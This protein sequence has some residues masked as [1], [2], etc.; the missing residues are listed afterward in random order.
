MIKDYTMEEENNNDCLNNYCLNK[1]QCNCIFYISFLSLLS[2]I[3]GLYKG[4]ID[5]AIFVPGGVFLTSIL[6]WCDP[7]YDWRR[8][9]DISYVVFAYIYATLRILGSTY[10]LYF[11]IFMAAAIISFILGCIFAKME[12]YWYSTIFHMGIHIFANIANFIVFS[13]DILPLNEIT[14]FNYLL[15]YNTNVNNIDLIKK[16]IE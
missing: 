9:L 7:L 13:G 16:I 12:Y 14:I 6:N 5:I 3:Y 1:E 11:H 15:D 10:E 2:C 8:Y 4:Y